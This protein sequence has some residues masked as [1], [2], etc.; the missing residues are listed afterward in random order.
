M[1]NVFKDSGHVGP[2][3]PL[4]SG[5]YELILTVTIDNL[6]VEVDKVTLNFN[7]DSDPGKLK[8]FQ[9]SITI[10]TLSVHSQ[11]SIA[12]IIVPSILLL[13]ATVVSVIIN[14]YLC[15]MK[16]KNNYANIT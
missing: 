7:C 1:W 3:V 4:P 11:I 5:F 10:A 15:A 6:G 8:V 2:T 9:G 12:G 14:I 16:N 13:I